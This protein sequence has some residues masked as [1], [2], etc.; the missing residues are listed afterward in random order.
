MVDFKIKRGLSTTMFSSP[1]VINPRLIIEEGVWYLCIDTAD[2]FLGVSATDG[3][4]KLKRIN[5]NG[6]EAD[7]GDI[8]FIV[9]DLMARV[10]DLEDVSLFQKINDESELPA[11]FDDPSF[12]P[13]ITYYLIKDNSAF[14]FIFDK[15]SL[16]YFCTSNVAET[17]QTETVTKV[18]INE[19]SRLIVHYSTGKVEDLGHITITNTEIT[20][21][22][23]IIKM[24]DI[25]YTQVDGVIELP[26]FATKEYVDRRI[27]E[28][29]NPA[30]TI[31]TIY[32]G[33]ATPED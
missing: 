16:S 14:T 29:E 2:L 31:T 25:L 18:E 6:T 13:N 7:L 21:N 20:T 26:T 32:G 24:G 4:I 19:A 28:I 17:E 3:T 27:A 12:N 11:D 30:I 1:G 8:S 9:D 15:D 23:V 10:E 33:D 22:D 5:G